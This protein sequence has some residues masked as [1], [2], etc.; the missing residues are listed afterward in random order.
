[1][2]FDLIKGKFSCNKVIYSHYKSSL[3]SCLVNSPCIFLE[4][5]PETPFYRGPDKFLKGRI[6]YLTVQPVYTEPCKFCY[7]LQYR[8][9]F[10][11]LHCSAG[12]ACKQKAGQCKFC[13]H[14]RKGNRFFGREGGMN[15]LPKKFP[16]VTQ[17][18]SEIEKKRGSYDAL[19]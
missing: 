14:R 16:Q 17:L 13:P 15:H 9:P 12:T 6:F 7:R 5:I 10:K 2:G 8:L 4:E 3:L 18:F 11:N 19:I 1:M